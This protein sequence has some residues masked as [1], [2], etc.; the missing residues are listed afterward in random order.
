MADTCYRSF[1]GTAIAKYRCLCVTWKNSF[2]K[3]RL[4][5]SSIQAPQDKSFLYPIYG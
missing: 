4:A 3:V 5:F 2:T 1:S